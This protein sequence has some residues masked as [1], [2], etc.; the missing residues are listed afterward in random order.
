MCCLCVSMSPAVGPSLTE[1]EMRTLDHNSLSVHTKARQAL[2][3]LHKCWLNR[4]EKWSFSRR[5]QGSV[6]G[7]WIYNVL[8]SQPWSPFVGFC[9]LVSAV[10]VLICLVEFLLLSMDQVWKLKGHKTIGFPPEN[11]GNW[12]GF[13]VIFIVIFLGFIFLWSG[14][15]IHVLSCLP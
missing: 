3:C 4:N 2:K 15:V 7:H 5:V 12:G 11:I 6:F 1:F 8:A 13:V 14:C 10:C 9:N